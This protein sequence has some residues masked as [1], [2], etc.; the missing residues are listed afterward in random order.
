MLSLIGLGI[1]D[2]KSVAVEGLDL[3]KEWILN[4]N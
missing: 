1:G 3:I 4:L 2:G